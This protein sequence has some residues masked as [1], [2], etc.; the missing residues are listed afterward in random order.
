MALIAVFMRVYILYL[1]IK[2]K[3]LAENLNIPYF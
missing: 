3:K 1:P 2:I